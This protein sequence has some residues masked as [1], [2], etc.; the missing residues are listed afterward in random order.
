MKKLF[1]SRRLSSRVS[2]DHIGKREQILGYFLGPCMVS[3]VYNGL[4]GTYLTQFYTDVLGLA[5]AFLTM[6]PLFSKILSGIVSFLIGRLIDRTRTAQGKARPWI[7]ASGILLTV[8]GAL[9]YMVP[10]A[11]YA[12]QMIWVVISYNLFFSLAYAVYAMSHAL[13][14]PLSTRDTKERDGLAMLTSTGVSM[15]P[16]MLVTIIMPMLVKHIGVGTDSQSSWVT[17]MGVLSCIAI[18]ATLIEYYFTMERVTSEADDKC[19]QNAVSFAQQIKGCIHDKYWLMIIL[20][21]LIQH[22]CNG[23]SSSSMLYY[24][25]WVLGNSVDSGVVNQLLVNVI[26]QAPMGFGVL[27]LWPLVRKFGKRK[28]TIIGFA[29]ATIGCL[30]VLLSSDNIVLVLGG[31]L[32]KSVGSLPTYVSVAY[33]AE[34]L[35]HIEWKNGFRADGFSASVSSTGQTL[36]TGLCQTMLLGGIGLFGYISP[37]STSQVVAQPELVRGFFNWCFVGF[38]MIGYAISAIIIW[39]YDI[40]QRPLREHSEANVK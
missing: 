15:L 3:M 34:A 29:V 24:C 6:M 17:V 37:E 38:P 40:E 5:G 8:T 16:G 20:F 2:V 10:R 22:F 1:A 30:I 35:D 23:M 19:S 28:V 21:N 4:A 11:S 14:V 32:V 33:L 7:L 26:G 12:V 36:M 31:L 18:P 25:N 39:F 9:M 27:F 13:M